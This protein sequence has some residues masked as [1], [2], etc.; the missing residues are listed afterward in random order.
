MKEL[1]HYVEKDISG[2]LLD[3]PAIKKRVRELG[4][5]ISIDY[6]GKNMVAVCILRGCVVFFSDLIREIKIPIELDFMAVSS[7]NQSAHSSGNVHIKYDLQDDIR[8]KHVLIVEDIIDTGTTL[9]HLKKLLGARQP[10]SIKICCLLDKEERR[11]AHV[12]VDYI[13]FE[14]PDEFVVGYGL[15]YA[16][17]YRNYREIGILKREIY[18]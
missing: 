8:G 15:D 5:Q 7:Y 18:E 16:G 3:E 17:K 10:E 11:L 12:D 4:E 14:I 2:V 1:K 6:E 13:G 9:M